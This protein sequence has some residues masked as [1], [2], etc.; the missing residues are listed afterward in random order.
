MKFYI[1][2]ITI[3]NS[4]YNSAKKN[5]ATLKSMLHDIDKDAKK[6][7]GKNVIT[8]LVLQEYAFTE[9][10]IDNQ[11]KKECIALLHK[12]IHLN[13]Q[14][15]DIGIIICREHIYEAPDL[16]DHSPFIQIIISDSVS[17]HKSHLYGALNIHMDS[18]DGLTI[19]HNTQHSESSKIESIQGM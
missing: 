6:A 17:T 15:I 19:L 14:K 7:Q 4:T 3:N 8:I 10:A 1:A 5:C 11:E 2:G 18:K 13:G 12:S 9:K 16:K